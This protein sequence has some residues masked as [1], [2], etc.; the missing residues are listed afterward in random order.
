MPE[1]EGSRG[2]GSG[3]E[4]DVHSIALVGVTEDHRGR[5]RVSD[6]LYHLLHG[7]HL[8][9][10]F[11]AI[12]SRQ[13]SQSTWSCAVRVLWRVRETKAASWQRP[14]RTRTA[15]ALARTGTDVGRR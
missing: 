5:Q 10:S 15:A 2:D 11:R 13:D 14:L 12:M 1:S 9:K 6:A 8:H 4:A 7:S 3:E